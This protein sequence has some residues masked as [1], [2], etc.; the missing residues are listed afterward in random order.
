MIRIALILKMYAK[1]KRKCVD[2]LIHGTQARIITYYEGLTCVLSIVH[3]LKK[4]D[5]CQPN[6]SLPG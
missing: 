4:G 1:K 3:Q 6:F 2:L 5:I